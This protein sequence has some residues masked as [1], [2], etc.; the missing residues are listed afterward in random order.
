MLLRREIFVGLKD[1]HEGCVCAEAFIYFFRLRI[2]PREEKRN[3][4]EARKLQTPVA[5]DGLKRPEMDTN[6]RPM[7][8]NIVSWKHSPLS[9]LASS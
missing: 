3:R 7:D 2:G 4:W 8:A 9:R 6:G 5:T 1:V